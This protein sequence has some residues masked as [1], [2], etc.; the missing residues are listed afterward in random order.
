MPTDYFT[1][2]KESLL[3]AETCSVNR[4]RSKFQLHRLWDVL[5][6]VLFMLLLR[7]TIHQKHD[8]NVA[9]IIL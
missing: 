6:K 7:M 4:P 1:N 3:K 8:N 2:D 9:F 5:R